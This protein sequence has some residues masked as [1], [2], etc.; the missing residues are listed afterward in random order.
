VKLFQPDL[1]YFEPVALDYLL[2]RELMK[3]FCTSS[4]NRITNLPGST[5]LEKIPHRQVYPGDRRAQNARLRPVKAV[6]RVCSLPLA[7]GCA[8]HCHYCNLQTSS[9]PA[10]RVY[11]NLDEI[12]AQAKC[13]SISA[14][15]RSRSSKRLAPPIP[16]PLNLE[17][18]SLI[19]AT[20]PGKQRIL[21]FN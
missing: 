4:Q 8:G 14:R 9:A 15:R 16:S 21:R 2:E 20:F 5:D 13:T 12:F 6:S 11:V 18:L 19:P 10:I 17:I 3:R 7:T 1:V